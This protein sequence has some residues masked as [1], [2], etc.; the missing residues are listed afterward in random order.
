MFR[1]WI[2]AIGRDFNTGT[3]DLLAVYSS[4]KFVNISDIHHAVQLFKLHN[5]SWMDFSNI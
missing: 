1:T 4:D 5:F 3:S 2:R